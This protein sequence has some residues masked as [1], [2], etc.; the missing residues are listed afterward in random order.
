MK[1][2]VSTRRQEGRRKETHENGEALRGGGLLAV[3]VEVRVRLESTGKVDLGPLERARRGRVTA[4]VVELEDGADRGDEERERETVAKAL[5]EPDA[6]SSFFSAR[7]NP[8]SLSVTE[9]DVV[10]HV[11]REVDGAR[12][13]E[14]GGVLDRE[15]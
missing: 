3:L 10:R 13:G 1:V 5:V 14:L 11:A 15:G 2:S 12:V 4:E 9:E 7:S 8:V 6:Y